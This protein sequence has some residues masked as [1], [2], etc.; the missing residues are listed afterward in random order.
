[1]GPLLSWLCVIADEPKESIT[2]NDVYSVNLSQKND[3]VVTT[4]QMIIGSSQLKPAVTTN[5]QQNTFDY[6]V[7]SFTKNNLPHSSINSENIPPYQR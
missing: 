4:A 3:P 2:C 6:A 1:M 5:Q 7:A